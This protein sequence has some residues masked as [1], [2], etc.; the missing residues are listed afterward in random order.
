MNLQNISILMMLMMLIIHIT[1]S[2]EHKLPHEHKPHHEHHEKHKNDKASSHTGFQDPEAMK[3]FLFNGT[4]PEGQ[5][6]TFE[7]GN[8]TRLDANTCFTMR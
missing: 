5:L 6:S 4:L 8:P 3:L 7:S 1:Y 2:I